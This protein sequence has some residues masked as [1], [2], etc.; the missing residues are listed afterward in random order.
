MTLATAQIP[1]V[2]R[3]EPDALRDRPYRMSYATY[4]R[5]AEL[6]LIRPEEHVVLLDG[7]LV[8]SMTK[9][10]DH[11]LAMLRG[12]D[13]LRNACPPGWHVRPEQPI[14]LP[15]E[16]GGDSAP[17]P[18]LSVA[19]GTIDR[20]PSRHPGIGEVGLVVE[21]ATTGAML[22]RDRSGLAR[23]AFAGIPTVWIVTLYDRKVHIHTE[24]SGPTASPGYARV[25][26]KQAGD[27]IE[28]SLPPTGEGRPP[29]ALGPIAVASFFPP[30]A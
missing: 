27:L 3:A 20:Y 10:P 28:A 19:V 1:P 2:E 30:A 11:S 6:G 13:V 26:V 24:P 5:I 8:H 15:N 14:A 18:D 9:G 16:Q 7:I 17:E 4:E 23:Y 29:A 22:S 25:A 12:Q 21:V